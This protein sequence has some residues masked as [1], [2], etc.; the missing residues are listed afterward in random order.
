MPCSL[1]AWFE[2]ATFD[3]ACFDTTLPGEIPTT[4]I[5]S[6]T[7]GRQGTISTSKERTSSVSTSKENS[8]T[9]SIVEFED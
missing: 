5:V 3:N 4:V 1:N 9:V 8:G 6:I 7:Q 2:T